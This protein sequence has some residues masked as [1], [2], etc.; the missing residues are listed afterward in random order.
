MM[1]EVGLFV[2]G[3]TAFICYGL[4]I[5]FLVEITNIIKDMRDGGKKNRNI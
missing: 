4:F 5:G 1:S 3:F 2:I